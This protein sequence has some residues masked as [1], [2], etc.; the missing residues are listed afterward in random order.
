LSFPAED[1]ECAGEPYVPREGWPEGHRSGFVAVMGAPNVGKST[2]LNAILGQKIVI[3]SPKPQTTR[4]RVLG[5]LTRADAQIVF[6]DTPGVHRPLHRLGEYMVEAARQTLDEAD[7][8][9]WLVDASRE[10]DSE[11]RLVATALAEHAGAAR[12]LVLNKTDLV[13][14][15]HIAERQEEYLALLPAVRVLRTSALTG[16][17]LDDVLAWLLEVLPQGPPYYP[18]DQVTDREERF[19]AAELVREQALRHLREEVPHALAVSVDEYKE[20]DN[21]VVYIAASLFVE[22]ESQKRI[23]IGAGGSVLKSISTEARQE[24]ERMV[25]A[26]VYLQLWV[27]VRANWRRNPVYLRGLGYRLPRNR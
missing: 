10:P 2:L 16:E 19:L 24:I 1:G 8:V 7:A 11:D 20:R 25:G 6:M 21:G 13:G 15:A 9:L 5:I 23:V 3:V 26:P 4:H 27:K 18:E 22:K 12:A 14:E 17:G